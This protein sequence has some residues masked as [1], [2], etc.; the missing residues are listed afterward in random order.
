MNAGA[1]PENQQAVKGI[2]I[3]KIY[4]VIVIAA[5][6][7]TAWLIVSIYQTIDSYNALSA[8]IENYISCQHD[9]DDL[10]AASDYLTEQARAFAATGDRQ[11]LDNYFT[12]VNETRRRD[13]ALDRFENALADTEA[14]LSLKE[15]LHQSTSLE[16]IEYYSMALMLDA[17]NIDKSD[18]PET[19]QAISLSPEDSAL[20]AQQKAQKAQD[21]LYDETYVSYKDSIR[22]NVQA[23]SDALI[24]ITK[25][26]KEQNAAQMLH[27][28]HR[29]TIL[30]VALLIVVFLVGLL[31]ALLVIRPISNG[32]SYIRAQQML[33]ETGSW[34]MRF[35]A[36]TY[37]NMFWE[38]QKHH[39]KLSFEASHDALTGLYN[40]A[41][42]EK[43][44]ELWA[45]EQPD[46]IALLLIDIDYFKSMNDTY[47]HSVGDEVLVKVA[48]ILSRSFRSE[49]YVCR[50]GGDEFAVIMVNASSALKDLIAGKLERA[51][52]AL[53]NPT[54][55]TPAVT[56]SIGV[57]FSDRENPTDSIY[58]DADAALYKVKNRG[59]NGYEFY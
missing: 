32:I 30:T 52:E 50:I 34:E 13:D 8:A 12:E 57:A 10:L 28:L 58:N 14:S 38:M 24:E 59:R 54:D 25:T 15:A 42:F 46:N 31:T 22:Q 4:I 11:Y 27:V 51:L 16:E 43:Q 37:N 17:K 23:C 35:L 20:S 36:R 33:P 1:R 18:L 6:A 55:D 2:S 7:I 53:R 47:G 29:Q 44:Q 49:D 45:Q 3:K 5:A 19:L 26:E 9:V 48:K 40:R 21:I 56:L 41:I 39:E